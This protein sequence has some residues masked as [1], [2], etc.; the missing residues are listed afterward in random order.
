MSLGTSTPPAVDTY[1]SSSVNTKRTSTIFI[2]I[3][4]SIKNVYTIF[5][6]DLINDIVH[7]H[8]SGTEPS[9]VILSQTCS[10][11]DTPFL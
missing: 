7:M 6:S 11:S 4:T 8:I 1:K 3:E 9:S 5:E 10:M 2:Q